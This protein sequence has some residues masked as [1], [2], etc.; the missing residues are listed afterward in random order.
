MEKIYP[1][2]NN[3]KA[4]SKIRATSKT[5]VRDPDRN[6]QGEKKRGTG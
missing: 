4:Q 5:K 2:S 3:P 6:A 1:K